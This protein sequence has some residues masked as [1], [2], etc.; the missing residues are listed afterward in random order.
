MPPGLATNEFASVNV[1]AITRI[2]RPRSIPIQEAYEEDA[3][4][5]SQNHR[6]WEDTFVMWDGEDSL[7]TVPAEL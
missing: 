5:P 2:F 7:P 1:P 3:R 4:F 6:A